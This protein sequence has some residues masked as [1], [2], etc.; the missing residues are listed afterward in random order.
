[1]AYNNDKDKIQ[2]QRITTSRS[3]CEN[4]STE[5][6]ERESSRRRSPMDVSMSLTDL[7]KDMEHERDNT[8]ATECDLSENSSFALDKLQA[9]MQIGST[10]RTENLPDDFIGSTIHTEDLPQ[11]F[12]RVTFMTSVRKSQRSFLRNDSAIST[13]V[14]QPE[15]KRL[16]RFESISK[17][18]NLRI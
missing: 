8:N 16:V 12:D 18:S 9:D 14:E 13:R 10:I 7:L 2:E 15:C 1:M 6:K 17:L 4:D 5:Q 11:S 3:E